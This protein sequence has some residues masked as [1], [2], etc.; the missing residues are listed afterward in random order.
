MCR[1]IVKPPTPRVR[2]RHALR[3]K[4]AA[5]SFRCSA[6]PSIVYVVA[7]FYAGAPHHEQTMAAPREEAA[8]LHAVAWRPHN[9]G[10]SMIVSTVVNVP[11]SCLSGSRSPMRPFKRV[12]LARALT[13]VSVQLLSPS[14]QSQ[15]G[16]N[17]SP[18]K[19]I[20]EDTR[21]AP[22]VAD[23]RPET[24]AE[25]GQ[26]RSVLGIQVRTKTEEAM[27]RIIDLLADRDGKMV[28]AVIEFGGFLGIGT[29]KIAV[30]WSALRIEADKSPVAILDVTW[31]QLRV[32]PE[33]KPDRPAAVFRVNQ[34]ASPTVETPEPIAKPLSPLPA[35]ED[36]VSK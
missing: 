19:P 24:A 33:Y 18:R 4:T 30:E 8:L 3:E 31:E 6:L 26:P 20:V 12:C 29:R 14:A 10:F 15:N 11:N 7:V 2:V 35:P 27:G 21:A 9:S 23:Q 32:A 17:P 36:R 28:A 16:T 25:A 5:S 34:P 22:Y 13:L 1:A